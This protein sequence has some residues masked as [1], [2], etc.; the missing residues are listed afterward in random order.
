MKTLLTKEQSQHIINL[1]V[2]EEKASGF[3]YIGELKYDVCDNY[4][5]NPI[6][7]KAPIFKLEDFLNGE[8]LPKEIEVEQSNLK[9]WCN[10]NIQINKLYAEVCYETWTDMGEGACGSCWIGSPTFRDK[11]FIDALYQLVCWYY[12]EHLK[13]KRNE[14]KLN[15]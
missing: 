1:G 11:E 8:I 2:P 9:D 14:R 7:E 12:G 15:N 6:N 13:M 4:F 10:L 5:D 3:E